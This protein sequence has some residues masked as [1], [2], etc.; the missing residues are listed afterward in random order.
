MSKGARV[1][2]ERD[3]VSKQLL[4]QYNEYHTNLLHYTVPAVSSVRRHSPSRS[5]KP[6]HGCEA[7]VC[8]TS[9]QAALQHSPGIMLVFSRTRSRSDD[10]SPSSQSQ[11]AARLHM[12][13]HAS[14]LASG[15]PVERYL[16]ALLP[17]NLG[18]DLGR[19]KARRDAGVGREPRLLGAR[20]TQ[21][22]RPALACW[23]RRRRGGLSRPPRGATAAPP[24]AT[25][26]AVEETAAVAWTALSLIFCTEGAL[27]TSGIACSQCRAPSRRNFGRNANP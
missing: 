5:Q 8:P 22:E 14:V 15:V 1:N 26:E 23:R 11:Q 21:A 7:R 18:A 12:S 9:Q 27:G 10:I 19:G 3:H 20:A 2:W 25:A 24:P 4:Y 17:L 16:R 6:E 13:A